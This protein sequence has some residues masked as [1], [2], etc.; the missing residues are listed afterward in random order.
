MGHYEFFYKLSR[1]FIFPQIR[2]VGICG[3]ECGPEFN[4]FT[5]LVLSVGMKEFAFFHKV[6][7]LEFGVI[8]YSATHHGNVDNDHKVELFQCKTLSRFTKP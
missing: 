6:G 5:V 3:N 8:E 7:R 2:L 4:F 1:I